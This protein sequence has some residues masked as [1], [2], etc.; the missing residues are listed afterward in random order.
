MGLMYVSAGYAEKGLLAFQKAVEADSN[1]TLSLMNIGNYFFRLNIFEK[2]SYFYRKA[3]D[4]IFICED[5]Q[6]SSKM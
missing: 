3:L 6:D 2:A 1:H 4:S 5:M